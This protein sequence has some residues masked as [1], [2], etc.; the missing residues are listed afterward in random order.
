MNNGDFSLSF[1]D[2]TEV[3]TNLEGEEK[4]QYGQVQ[5]VDVVNDVVIHS[6][7]VMFFEKG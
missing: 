5:V 4:V 7:N 1:D 2:K 3:V 6:I